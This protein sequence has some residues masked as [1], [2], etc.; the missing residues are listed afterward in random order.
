[1]GEAPLDPVFVCSQ[2]GHRQDAEGDCARCGKDTVHDLRRS[3]TRDLLGDIDLRRRDKIEGQSRAIAVIGAMIIVISPW[4]I[5][6]NWSEIRR[7]AFAIP[8]MADQIILMVLVAFGLMKLLEAKLQK[9][10]FPYLDSLPP[11]TA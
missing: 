4:F 9:P 11:P 6:P 5:V 10:R 8:L 3:T 2:C 7:N 1:M